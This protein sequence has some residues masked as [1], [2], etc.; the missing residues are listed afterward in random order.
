MYDFAL[1]QKHYQEYINLIKHFI[2]PHILNSPNFCLKKCLLHYE[3]SGP[4]IECEYVENNKNGKNS[5]TFG[6]YK[7]KATDQYWLL[8]VRDDILP[9]LKNIPNNHDSLKMLLDVHYLYLTLTSLTT[10][11]KC[12]KLNDIKYFHK[13]ITNLKDITNCEVIPR[14][15]IDA[16]TMEVVKIDYT[17]EI[18]SYV[19]ENNI[20]EKNFSFYTYSLEYDFLTKNTTLSFKQKDCKMTNGVQTSAK[21]ITVKKEVFK[22][23]NDPDYYLNFRKALIA[24]MF[25]NVQKI[26][27]TPLDKI[28]L[29]D[30]EYLSLL[31]Y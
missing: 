12:N 24:N 30:L 23:S 10:S 21:I 4:E 16:T 18:F 20:E 9:I 13:G 15:S 8:D 7:N 29:R 3:H 26:L 11:F 25:N 31:S 6:F 5:V 28:N 14:F 19:I 1:T 2:Y 17:G 22:E 27:D